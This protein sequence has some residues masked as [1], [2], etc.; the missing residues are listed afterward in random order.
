MTTQIDVE[1][2]R[3]NMVEQQI[4]PWEVLDQQVLDLLF[5]VHREDFVP[6][7]YRNLAFADL[8]IPIGHGE[9]ML[10][11]R[12]EARM[13]QALAVQPTDRVLE[14]GTGSGYMTALL[15]KRG[16]HVY[17][18]EIVPELSA[19]ARTKL[20]QHE[21]AN[22][23]LEVGDAARG[24]ASRAPY[25]VVV[26]TGSVPVL[27]D[28]FKLSLNPGGRLLAVV[29]DAPVMEARLITSSGGGMYHSA[30][31]FETC[32]PQLRNAPQPESFAF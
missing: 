4:R 28:E 31:L 24:W 30:G 23:T 25:D 13:L 29:G 20:A 9:L 11:P 32:I 2:A 8:E 7:Q 14:I 19:E 21:I 1:R 26:L 15:A 10:A 5:A 16:A 6:R 18:V 22:V 3:F 17:S 12:I 27:A